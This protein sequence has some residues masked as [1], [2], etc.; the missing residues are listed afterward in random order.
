MRKQ[1]GT[2]ARTKTENAKVLF[3]HFYKVI[4]RKELSAYYPAILQEIDLRPTNTSLN[5]SPTQLEV[6]AALQK[7]Q[8]EKSPGKKGI[9]KEAFQNLKRRPLS[10][11]MKL[12]ALSWKNDQFNPVDW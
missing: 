1:D 9:P 10:V 7:M 5:V 3:D 6:K 11:C 2:F 8:Y 12:I 4:N